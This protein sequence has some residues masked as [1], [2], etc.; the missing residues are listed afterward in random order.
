MELFWNYIF[1]LGFWFGD[2]FIDYLLLC[3]IYNVIFF[4][5]IVFFLL[6]NEV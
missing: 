4:F 6:L 3:F 5:V 1:E 2:R